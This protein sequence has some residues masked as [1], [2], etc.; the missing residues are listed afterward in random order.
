[1]Y[2]YA[3]FK[4]PLTPLTLPQGMADVVQTIET[5]Q[6]S[7]V[8][9][10]ALS[11]DRLQQ[12]D[13]LLVQAVIAHD[14]ILRSLFLQTAILPLRF[15]TTFSS[16]HSLLTHLQSHQQ[17]YLSK[18]AQLEGKAEYTLKLTPVSFPECA[19]APGVRGKDYFIAKKQQYQAQLSYQKQQQ[20]AVWQ[21]EQ[22]LIHAYPH[23]H[24]TQAETGDRTLYLLVAH[25]REEQL[26]QRV[27]TLQQ[28]HLQWTLNLGEA[29]PP[30]H[31]VT[32]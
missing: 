27:Q 32:D 9:E 5:G 14:R 4:T 25:D 2:T 8:I 11:I 26:C 24:C 21:I 30:Y 1:M 7:A 15:G 19:I 13:T 22:A 6:L 23:Y 28:H 18:L 20:E 29:L 12:D 16:L 17:T 3:F 10:P 31:F